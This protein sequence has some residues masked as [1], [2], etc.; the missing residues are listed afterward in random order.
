M[1]QGATSW[2][3]FDVDGPPSPR[4]GDQEIS[5]AAQEGRYL[6]DADGFGCRRTLLWRVNNR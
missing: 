5:V 3:F 2:P 1:S 6:Q 4:G